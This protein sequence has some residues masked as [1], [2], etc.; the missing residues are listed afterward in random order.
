MNFDYDCCE[1]HFLSLMSSPVCYQRAE[2]IEIILV[3]MIPTK[4][5]GFDSVYCC[6]RKSQA[7][8]AQ[9]FGPWQQATIEITRRDH[10]RRHH[11]Q[12]QSTVHQV[13]KHCYRSLT[14]ITPSGSLYYCLFA[15]H[16]ICSVF[17]HAHPVRGVS[18]I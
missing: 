14:K 3:Y 18:H 1:S 6:E 13:H 9:S 8:C 12:A 7:A 15:P 16:I 2:W 4:P 17:L 11:S 5:C 10:S